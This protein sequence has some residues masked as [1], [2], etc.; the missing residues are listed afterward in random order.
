[1]ATINLEKVVRLMDGSKDLFRE[2][3]QIIEDSLPEKFT[4]LDQAITNQNGEDLE[5]AAHQFKG[6]LRNIAAEDACVLLE[7]L[8][9]CGLHSDFTT[10][11]DLHSQVKPLVDEL[12]GYYRKGEWEKAF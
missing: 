10:A 2:L 8:E 11:R 7:R 9:K 6:A 4:R 5:M 12:L 1:M 3:M